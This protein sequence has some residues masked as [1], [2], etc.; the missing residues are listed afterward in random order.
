MLKSELLFDSIEV[1]PSEVRPNIG[2]AQFKE[3]THVEIVGR[4][5][6]SDDF[7]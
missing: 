6:Q 3:W 4:L 2:A 5:E 1:L 7:N